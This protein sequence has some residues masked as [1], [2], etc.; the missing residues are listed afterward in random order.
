MP[1][2][3]QCAIGRDTYDELR[4]ARISD[5]RVATIDGARLKL[6]HGQFKLLFELVCNH[7]RVVE[8]TELL[9]KAWGGQYL[10][11]RHI[12]VYIRRLRLKLA[13]LAHARCRIETVRGVGYCITESQRPT[14]N[15]SSNGCA[16]PDGR[17]IVST[18]WT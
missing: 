17:P 1:L 3:R 12:T 8:R 5:R 15:G 13:K 14:E 7:G 9:K 16:T 4:A 6:S 10:E 11:S 18:G 2:W